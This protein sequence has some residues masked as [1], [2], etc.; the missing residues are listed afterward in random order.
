MELTYFGN[1][2]I[3]GIYEGEQSKGGVREPVRPVPGCAQFRIQAPTLC[4]RIE[5]GKLIDNLPASEV[6]HRMLVS[7]Y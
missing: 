5:Q 1:C 3:T 4:S 7:F 6:T 2:S